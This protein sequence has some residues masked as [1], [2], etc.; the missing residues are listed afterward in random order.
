M[1][2]VIK[3]FGPAIATID[4]AGKR[5][6]ITWDRRR[7]QPL[8]EGTRRR[9]LEWAIGQLANLRAEGYELFLPDGLQLQRCDS[10]LSIVQTEENC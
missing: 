10:N 6:V 4:H 7:L 9:A 3:H 1:A 2:A 8:S 5:V